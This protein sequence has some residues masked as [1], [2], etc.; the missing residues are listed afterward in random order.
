MFQKFLSLVDKISLPADK[1]A[2][3]IQ[4]SEFL[5]LDFD[6]QNSVYHS[7]FKSW[8]HLNAPPPPAWVPSEAEITKTNIFKFMQKVNK[9]TFA[10]LHSWSV[11]NREEFWNEVVQVLGITFEKPYTS[12]LD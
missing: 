6:S 1:W 11:Q 4:S 10:E 2:A 3:L 7:I 12:V 5:G 9:K 8:D